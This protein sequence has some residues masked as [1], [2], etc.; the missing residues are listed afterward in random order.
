MS[1]PCDV[2]RLDRSHH[3][4]ASNRSPALATDGHEYKPARKAWRTQVVVPAPARGLSFMPPDLRR[5]RGVSRRTSSV[6][7][8]AALMGERYAPNR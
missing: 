7:A 3:P 6:L 5:I 1:K 4:R 8:A 2:C